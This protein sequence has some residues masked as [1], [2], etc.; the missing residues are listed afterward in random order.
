MPPPSVTIIGAADAHGMLGRDVR[1]NKGDSFTLDLTD[2]VT[3]AP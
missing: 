2:Q 1:S 3:A